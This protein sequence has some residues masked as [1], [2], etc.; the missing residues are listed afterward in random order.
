MFRVK[1]LA[2]QTRVLLTCT[3]AEALDLLYGFS[4][5]QPILRL[6][7]RHDPRVP[8][9]EHQP[10]WAASNLDA[11]RRGGGGHGFVLC[12]VDTQGP[13]WV[14]TPVLGYK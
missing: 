12:N 11:G 4:S 6:Y 3:H 9:G 14:K 1:T 10:R 13:H 5:T 2:A 8:S 7:M